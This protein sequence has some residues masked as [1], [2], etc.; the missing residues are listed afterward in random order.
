M[1][2][3]AAETKVIGIMMP[4]DIN[5]RISPTAQRVVTF[6]PKEV[7]LVLPLPLVLAFCTFPLGDGPAKGFISFLR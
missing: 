6:L 4:M 3:V 7:T 5:K 2:Q 1:G